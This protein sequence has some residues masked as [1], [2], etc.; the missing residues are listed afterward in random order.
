M[1]FFMFLL[2]LGLFLIVDN[3]EDMFKEY[4]EKNPKSLALSKL[5]PFDVHL[6]KNP[7]YFRRGNYHVLSDSFDNHQPRMF[8]A[9]HALFDA[10]ANNAQ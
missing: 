3:D 1:V 10:T 8:L 7:F 5:Q 4:A 6:S 9:F 2:V